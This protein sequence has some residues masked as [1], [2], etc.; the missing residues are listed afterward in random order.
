MCLQ[1]AVSDTT[2]SLTAKVI[3]FNI[4]QQLFTYIEKLQTVVFCIFFVFKMTIR[5]F[6]TV[7][8]LSD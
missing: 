4:R 8:Q 2:S 3:Q 5:R 1:I 6:I 7:I